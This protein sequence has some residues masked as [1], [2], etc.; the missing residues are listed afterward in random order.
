M[1]TADDKRALKENCRFNSWCHSYQLVAGAFE[2][3]LEEGNPFGV[4]P[5]H[6]PNLL[7]NALLCSSH[8]AHVRR[9]HL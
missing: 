4:F 6:F 1:E 5:D 8:A 2:E 3:E 9:L 7:K